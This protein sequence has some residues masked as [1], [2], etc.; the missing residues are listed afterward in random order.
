MSLSKNPGQPRRVSSYGGNQVKSVPG[1]APGED[2]ITC[3][4]RAAAAC[5]VGKIGKANFVSRGDKSPLDSLRMGYRNANLL[6]HGGKACRIVNDGDG[7]DGVCL[8]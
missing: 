7:V 1:P 4:H 3:G 5:A 6:D 2:T 8:L